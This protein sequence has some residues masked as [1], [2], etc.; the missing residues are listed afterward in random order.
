MFAVFWALAQLARGRFFDVPL[1]TK[2]MRH[3]ASALSKVI[4]VMPAYNAYRRETRY[5]AS[6]RVTTRD[7]LMIEVPRLPRVKRT[8]SRF[9]LGLSVRE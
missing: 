3:V 2:S 7:N 4:W 5:A 1:P 8:D 9:H 6:P